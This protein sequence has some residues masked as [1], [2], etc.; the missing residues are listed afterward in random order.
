TLNATDFLERLRGQKVAFAGD[1]L[2]RNMFES[3]ACI[4]WN[5]VPDKSR[6]FWLGNVENNIR[7]QMS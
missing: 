4:L 7:E 5:A 2:N 3:L 1:S 6:V